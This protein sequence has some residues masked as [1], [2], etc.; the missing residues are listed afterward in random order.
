VVAV[1]AVGG[2]PLRGFAGPEVP[3][4]KVVETVEVV[5]WAVL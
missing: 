2:T 5:V 1:H 3:V 4:Q